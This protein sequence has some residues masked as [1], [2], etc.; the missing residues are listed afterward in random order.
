MAKARC[1]NPFTSNYGDSQRLPKRRSCALCRGR[2]QRPLPPGEA[3][4][5]VVAAHG[6]GG[7][8]AQGEAAGD[9]V[10]AEFA[11]AAPDPQ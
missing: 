5:A 2:F 10:E 11:G 8:G 6:Q 9:G 7:A 4:Q 3:R 1:Y